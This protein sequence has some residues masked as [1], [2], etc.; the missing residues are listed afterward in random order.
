MHDFK[1]LEVWKRSRLLVKDVFILLQDFP[2][3]E[4]FGLV[5]QMKRA[6]ISIPSNIAEGCGRGSNKQLNYHLGVA[7]GSVYEL[8]TQLLISGDLKYIKEEKL[9]AVIE[10]VQEVGRMLG[11]LQKSLSLS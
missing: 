1:K 5:S 7:L 11:G 3:E 9:N 4:V 8:G 2:K 10:K 6:S